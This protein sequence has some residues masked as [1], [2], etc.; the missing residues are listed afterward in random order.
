MLKPATLKNGY[1]IAVPLFCETGDRIEIDTTTGE[2]R[3]R[4]NG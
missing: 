2:Y 3:R 1:Q 4:V